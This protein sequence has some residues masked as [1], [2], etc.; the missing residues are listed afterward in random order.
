VIHG[1]LSGIGGEYGTD[2]SRRIK[3]QQ[4]FEREPTK[5]EANTFRKGASD[6]EGNKRTVAA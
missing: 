5:L 2:H 3:G 1:S 6:A 4:N